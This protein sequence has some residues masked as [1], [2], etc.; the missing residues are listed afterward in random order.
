MGQ[1]WPPLHL[2]AFE[3]VR[4]V[5]QFPGKGL[6]WGFLALSKLSTFCKLS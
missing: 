6:N 4:K 3:G 1:S 2:Q 5:T